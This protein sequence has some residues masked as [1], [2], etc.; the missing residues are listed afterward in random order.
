MP[1]YNIIAYERISA[2]QYAIKSILVHP[3]TICKGFIR[4]AMGKRN[5]GGLGALPQFSKNSWELSF[6]S[7]HL[8]L[9]LQSGSRCL[10]SRKIKCGDVAGRRNIEKQSR[11]FFS[12]LF[13]NLLSNFLE[14]E[15]SWD[16]K[17]DFNSHILV[18]S[19]DLSIYFTVPYFKYNAIL[20]I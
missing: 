1:V 16:T 14:R 9:F 5:F 4:K 12:R 20:S 18:L 6:Y 19:H 7:N 3:M 8:I 2:P 15:N 11:I 10:V 17:I 13:P